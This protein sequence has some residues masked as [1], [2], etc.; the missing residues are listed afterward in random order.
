MV[1]ANPAASACCAAL[2]AGASAASTHAGSHR[3]G[4]ADEI[5]AAARRYQSSGLAG[6]HVLPAFQD[7]VAFAA[8]MEEA[9][10]GTSA[11]MGNDLEALQ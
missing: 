6:L 7:F 1:T 5:G 11:E 3:A 10:L 4:H 8:A 2:Q 9:L